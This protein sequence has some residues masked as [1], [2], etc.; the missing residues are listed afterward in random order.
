MGGKCRARR[1][2]MQSSVGL[3]VQDSSQLR[4]GLS[5]TVPVQSLDAL[6]LGADERS[7]SFLAILPVTGSKCGEGFH[8]RDIPWSGRRVAMLVTATKD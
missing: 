7:V 2:G 4:L 6:L 1:A 5:Q 8:R 3:T